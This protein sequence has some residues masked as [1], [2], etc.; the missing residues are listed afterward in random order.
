MTIWEKNL[1][2]QN[3]NSEVEKASIDPKF[4]LWNAYFE[5]N[6]HYT[7]SKLPNQL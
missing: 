1:I 7:K 3:R 2:K 5:Q 4:I 6:A